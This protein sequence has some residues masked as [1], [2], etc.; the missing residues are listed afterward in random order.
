MR[1]ERVKELKP[2]V[3]KRLTGMKPELF[4]EVAEVLQEAE[5]EKKAGRSSKLS[6]ED[7][8]LLALSYWREYQTQFHIAASYAVHESTSSGRLYIHQIEN[9]YY[10]SSSTTNAAAWSLSCVKL[11]C[12]TR[13]FFCISFSMDSLKR[14]LGLT[15]S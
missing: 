9:P 2:A 15:P 3:F 6:L 10:T 11:R 12:A 8:L 7:Q 4:I 13:P 14:S 1:Y 5:L